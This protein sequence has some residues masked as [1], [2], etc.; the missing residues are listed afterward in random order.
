MQP[1]TIQYA[2]EIALVHYN[3]MNVTYHLLL[4]K[5]FENK[6]VDLPSLS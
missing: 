1:N 2:T 6:W 5:L 4:N 3:Y